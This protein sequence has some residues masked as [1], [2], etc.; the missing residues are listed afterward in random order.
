[1]QSTVSRIDR[2]VV[3]MSSTMTTRDA[4]RDLEAAQPEL[5]AFPLDPD[6]RHAEW[7]EVS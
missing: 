5:A 7:R 2:P 6:R 3:T 4:L 1:M